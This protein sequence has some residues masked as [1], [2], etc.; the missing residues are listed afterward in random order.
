M[1]RLAQGWSKVQLLRFGPAA[2]LFIADSASF[3]PGR[4][5]ALFAVVRF[6]NS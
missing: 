4:R 2:I 1:H 6:A 3:F 5:L